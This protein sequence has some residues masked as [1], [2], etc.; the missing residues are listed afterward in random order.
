MK[1]RLELIIINKK[2]V[3]YIKAIGGKII[4]TTEGKDNPNEYNYCP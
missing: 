1:E 3:K 4:K 2:I